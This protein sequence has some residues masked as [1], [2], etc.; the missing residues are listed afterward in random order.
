MS[1][2]FITSGD[3][4]RRSLLFKHGTK[5]L[6]ETLLWFCYFDELSSHCNKDLACMFL[7]RPKTDLES[8]YISF[9][10]TIYVLFLPLFLDFLKTIEAL[11]C[12][13]LI[14]KGM[15]TRS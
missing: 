5:D 1:E 7:D 9:F 6:L 3:Y 2:I 14:I 12:D 4:G 13:L 15:L 8:E 11:P 10:S